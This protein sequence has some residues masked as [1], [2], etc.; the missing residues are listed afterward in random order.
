MT[1]LMNGTS[2]KSIEDDMLGQGFEDLERLC[3][4]SNQQ[5]VDRA[6]QKY[7][8]CLDNL[9]Q[10]VK[11]NEGGKNKAPLILNNINEMIR[12]AWAVPTHGHELG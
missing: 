3:A 8:H 11:R 5:D 10:T 1:Q 4:N 2:M 6:I 12:K 7:S 9:V